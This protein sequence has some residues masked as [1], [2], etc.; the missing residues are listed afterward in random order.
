MANANEE[1]A[2]AEVDKAKAA[3]QGSVGRMADVQSDG[4]ATV[5]AGHTF[6]GPVVQDSLLDRQDLQGSQGSLAEAGSGVQG[7]V[8][9]LQQSIH[10]EHC[11]LGPPTVNE[12]RGVVEAVMQCADKRRQELLA[13]M[14]S[15][16]E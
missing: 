4:G 15:L 10:N 3:S 6:R 7:H 8:Y 2:E 11:L 14:T 1:V 9:M 16:W 12:Q 13:S 5:N